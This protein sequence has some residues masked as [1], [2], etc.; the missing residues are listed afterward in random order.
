MPA[1]H[2]DMRLGKKAVKHDKRTMRLRDFLAPTLPPLPTKDDYSSGI[3]AWGMMANNRVGDCTIAGVGHATQVWNYSLGKPLISY[4][5]DQII[6][7]YSDW[8][9]YVV[10]DSSTDNGGVE[11]DVLNSWRRLGFYD[12][13]LLSYCAVNTLNPQHV[14]YGIHLFGVVYIGVELPITAQAQTEVWSL[15]TV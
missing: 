14:K 7:Y 12:H 2:A 10:G 3:T 13:P 6:K 4:T 8:D 15:P 5:D 11:L 9:G 1:N